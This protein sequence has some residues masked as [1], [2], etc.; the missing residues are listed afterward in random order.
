MITEWLV[1]ESCMNNA[2]YKEYP[3]TERNST[4]NNLS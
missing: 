2:I 4:I 3:E 1:G